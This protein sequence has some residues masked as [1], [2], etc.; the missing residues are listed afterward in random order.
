[1]A[2]LV[3]SPHSQVKSVSLL[4]FGAEVIVKPWSKLRHWD[5]AAE[6]DWCLPGY[7]EH[8]SR[9][10]VYQVILNMHLEGF[11]YSLLGMKIQLKKLLQTPDSTIFEVPRDPQFSVTNCWQRCCENKL[12]KLL[13]K[14]KVLD[15]SGLES[16]PCRLL[17][18]CFTVPLRLSYLKFKVR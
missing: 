5:D 6:W 10:C 17:G 13:V 12:R 9:R 2:F 11:C 18:D 14:W 1:M 3:W 15:K 4:T 7:H 16:W 8:A